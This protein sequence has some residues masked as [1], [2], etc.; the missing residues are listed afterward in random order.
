[1]LAFVPSRWFIEVAQNE[2]GEE[3]RNENEYVWGRGRIGI[4]ELE[5]RRAKTRFDLHCTQISLAAS[6]EK[7]KKKSHRTSASNGDNMHGENPNRNNFYSVFPAS[8]SLQTVIIWRRPRERDKVKQ[9]DREKRGWKSWN[10]F[11][12]MCSIEV[13]VKIA[14]LHSRSFIAM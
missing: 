14:V 8:K 9:S 3:K 2:Q 13:A 12:A 1:M 6:V 4:D 7:S 5:E 10:Q 11:I